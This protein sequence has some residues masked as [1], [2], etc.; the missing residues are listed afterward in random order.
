MKGEIYMNNSEKAKRILESEEIPENLKPE[1]IRIMLENQSRV[2]KCSGKPNRGQYT[3]IIAGLTACAVIST[4]GIYLIEKNAPN[5]SVGMR[6]DNTIGIAE[7]D[8]IETASGR[9][10]SMRSAESYDEIYDIVSKAPKYHFTEYEGDNSNNFSETYNQEEGVDEPNK[11]VTDGKCI[12][13]AV[14]NNINIALVDNGEFLYKYSF[15]ITLPDINSVQIRGMYILDESLVIISEMNNSQGETFTNILSYSIDYTTEKFSGKYP[16]VL[17]YQ[18]EYSQGGKFSDI[19]VIDDYIYLITS[20]DNY[21]S[22]KNS[23][24]YD[25]Y[26]PKYYTEGRKKNYIEPENIYIPENPQG[27]YNSYTVIGALKFNRENYA[28]I[29]TDNRIFIEKDIKA[30]LKSNETVYCS[31]DNLYVTM[32]DYSDLYTQNTNIFRFSLL[33]GSITPESAGNINGIPINQFSM[34]EYN[35]YF[36]IAVTYSEETAEGRNTFEGSE[37]VSKSIRKNNAVYILDM[38]M[39]Q[40]GKVTDFGIDENI[41]SVNFCDN[42]GY[43]VTYE[44]TDPIFAIDLSIPE[45]PVV[46]DSLELTGYSTYMQK[47]S[48]NLLLGFG[49]SADEDGT[50]NGFKLTMIDISDPYNI[51]DISTHE[52]TQD[53]EK[54]EFLASPA[55]NDRKSLL[56]SP[57]RNIIGVP[58]Y[59]QKYYEDDISL[60]YSFYSFNGMG[61]ESIGTVSGYESE[62][63]GMDRAV[64]IDDYIY[65]ICGNKFISFSMIDNEVSGEC[66]F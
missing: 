49:V 13:S 40:V 1:N 56:I 48:D 26:L 63:Y 47:W 18:G 5:K 15:D 46:T 55:F 9:N 16:V 4:S 11:T 37:T 43:V 51:G 33:E 6:S 8:D 30:F 2:R 44:Q 22:D 32:N 41:K 7:C 19:R 62:C 31:K 20:D 25:A 12:F 17:A 54:E 27:V 60:F 45:N 59:I 24:N 28:N 64:Y 39:N 21:T 57:D 42:M 23:E 36:R 34:S 38:N 10:L 58:Y 50:V 61:F 3:H 65:V 29:N 35:D 52:F 66:L 53:D 14:D